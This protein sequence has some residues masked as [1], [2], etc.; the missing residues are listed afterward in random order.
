MWLGIGC[1]ISGIYTCALLASLGAAHFPPIYSSLLPLLRLR[2]LL[3]SL[4]V[5]FVPP[6][7]QPHVDRPT[8]HIAIAIEASHFLRL[9]HYRVSYRE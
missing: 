9:R 8:N 7:I 3:Y 2:S 4:V 6:L 5:R 1:P